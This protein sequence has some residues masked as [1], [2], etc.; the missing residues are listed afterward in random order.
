[1]NSLFDE[2]RTYLVTK[3]K[4]TRLEISEKIIIGINLFIQVII[5]ALLST[6]ILI[7]ASFTLA[8]F[9]G[10]YWDNAGLG[11][12]VV[13]GID[14]LL[15]MIFIIFRKPLILKPLSK[16]LIPLLFNENKEEEGEDENDI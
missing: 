13:S 5:I 11:F 12:L 3:Y 16:I 2:I 9:L 15:L 6:V 4:I 7:V 10:S 8:N 1:M 14:I